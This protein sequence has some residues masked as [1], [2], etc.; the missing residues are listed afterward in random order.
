MA[1]FSDELIFIGN[2]ITGVSIIN[3]YIRENHEL[4]RSQLKNCGRALKIRIKN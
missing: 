4:R 3:A 2:F 1:T